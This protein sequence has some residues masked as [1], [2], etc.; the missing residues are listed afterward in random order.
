VSGQNVEF[1]G[2]GVKQRWLQKHWRAS[3]VK[4][5]WSQSF[6]CSASCTRSSSVYPG[7][8]VT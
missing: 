5:V 1:M 2:V 6:Y 3:S 8:R 4:Y 7:R